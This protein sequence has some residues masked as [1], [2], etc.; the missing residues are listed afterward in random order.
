MTGDRG[1]E[2]IAFLKSK[3][4]FGDKT[5]VIRGARLRERIPVVWPNADRDF[6]VARADVETDDG[7]STYQLVL[8]AESEPIGD[9]LENEQFRRGLI[10]AFAHGAAFDSGRAR[11]IIQS[12]GKRMLVAPPASTITLSKAEQSNTSVLVEGEAIL[13]LF[14]RLEPG[15]HPDV[16]VTR[17][18]TID[19][20]F[21]HTPVLLGTIRFEDAEG[22][23]TAGMLQELV[24]QAMD[25]WSFALECTREHFGNG[26][27]TD[28]PFLNEAEQL[29]IVTRALHETLASGAPG[30][31]FAPTQVQETDVKAWTDATARMARRSLESLRGAVDSIPGK[32]ADAARALIADRFT[33][34]VA[35]WGR[36]LANDAGLKTRVHGDYHLGQVLRSAANQFLIIDFEGEP[37]RPLAER[38]ALQSPLRDVAGMLRSFA[39]LAAVGAA[40]GKA[41]VDR[42]SRWEQDARA[43]FFRGYFADVDTPVRGLLPRDRRNAERLIRLFEAEKVFY[44]LQYELDHRPDWA[45]I[46]LRGITALTT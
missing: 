23:T 10:D 6:A 26:R 8:G 31:A 34:L 29:G 17:F 3:R 40:N 35:G 30:S 9:A 2:L 4:W 20:Q 19:R 1:G 24:P 42:A 32:H 33:E 22:T 25:G 14:R 46:P 21:L 12:E 7:T 41:G 28:M 5:K 16:E 18:L 45:W 44:E 27:G 11:W 38:R 39:Y 36:D 43:A 13:K 15:V 37:A